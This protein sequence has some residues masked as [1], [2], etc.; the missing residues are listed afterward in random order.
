M[1][2]GR[3]VPAVAHSGDVDGVCV[4]ISQ[5]ASSAKFREL[6]FAWAATVDRFGL[7]TVIRRRFARAPRWK[8]R[9]LVSETNNG[10]ENRLRSHKPAG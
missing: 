10:D 4:D 7:I 1:T 9:I 2:I 3:I 6:A 8:Q 5:F